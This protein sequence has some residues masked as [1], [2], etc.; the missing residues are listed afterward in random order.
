[1]VDELTDELRRSDAPEGSAFYSIDELSEK[2][3]VS[4]ITSRRV[5][6]ELENSGLISKMRGRNAVILRPN[7]LRKVILLDPTDCL[8]SRPDY[9]YICM[10]VYRGIIEELARRGIESTVI[11]PPHFERFDFSLPH[12][13]IVLPEFCRL[14]LGLRK[15][16]C[17]NPQLNVVVPHSLGPIAGIQTVGSDLQLEAECVVSHL[18]ERGARRV[19]MIHTPPDY[20]NDLKFQG[21]TDALAANGIA[22]DHK[23]VRQVE[24]WSTDSLYLAMAELLDEPEPPDALFCCNDRVAAMAADYCRSHGVAI[25]GDLLLAG[26]DNLPEAVRIAGGL[27]TVDSGWLEQGRMA[28]RMLAERRHHEEAK[29]ISPDVRLI[30]RNSTTKDVSSLT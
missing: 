8:Q 11:N 6:D 29:H 21:Y 25:P 23:L 3:S 20:W 14:S 17:E 7:P 22:F 10:A 26:F 30:V 18:I 5:L 12:D 19:A 4:S 1:M 2:Y 27:T 24:H 9:G 15:E 13:V 16:M 28:V